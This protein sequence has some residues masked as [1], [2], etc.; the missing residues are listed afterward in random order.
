[1][2]Y[3]RSVIKG[4]SCAI[5]RWRKILTSYTYL[6]LLSSNVRTVIIMSDNRRESD[7][8]CWPLTTLPPY[9]HP[10][11]IG[12]RPVCIRE[13]QVIITAMR[14]F[15]IICNTVYTMITST[16]MVANYQQPALCYETVLSMTWPGYNPGITQHLSIV[17]GVKLRGNQLNAAI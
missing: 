10:R 12:H 11:I 16:C 15:T 2:G 13:Y 1:M 6:T 14:T 9:C 4:Q 7:W 17:I 5:G 3:H 8:H